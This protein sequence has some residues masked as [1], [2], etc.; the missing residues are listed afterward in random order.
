MESNN[1]RLNASTPKATKSFRTRIELLNIDFSA[2]L[3]LEN[4][5]SPKINIEQHIE[6]KKIFTQDTFIKRFEMRKIDPTKIEDIRDLWFII[7]HNKIKSP[8]CN[9]QGNEFIM[10]QNFNTGE[11]TPNGY[12]VQDT[13]AIYKFIDANINFFIANTKN[14]TGDNNPNGKIGLYFLYD[15]QTNQNIGY[16]GFEPLEYKNGKIFKT[17]LQVHILDGKFTQQGVG[18]Q[19]SAFYRDNILLGKTNGEYNATLEF[20]PGATYQRRTLKTNNPSLQYQ[21]KVFPWAETQEE[22][23]NCIKTAGE[24]AIMIKY[25]KYQKGDIFAGCA[26]SIRQCTGGRCEIF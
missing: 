20:D 12:L 23:G 9:K 18:S 3:P 7:V 4:I 5:E 11:M 8:F 17:E 16:T 14:I 19:M 2:K 25:A 26:D 6:R 15:K 22:D 1:Q 10:Q 24:M 21:N 13:K